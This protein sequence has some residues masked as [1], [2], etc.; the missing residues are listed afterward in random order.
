[1]DWKN[2]GGRAAEGQA[3]NAWI[4]AVPM[5]EMAERLGLDELPMRQPGFRFYE[6]AIYHLKQLGFEGQEKEHWALQVIQTLFFNIG[7]RAKGPEGPI[8]R[9]VRWYKKR[10]AKG[11]KPQPFDEYFKYAFRQK[12]FTARTRWLRQKQKSGLSI[13]YT[14][15]GEEEGGVGEE[16]F[17]ESREPSPYEV[18]R[19]KEENPKKEKA[20]AEVPQMLVEHRNGAAYETIWDLMQKQK[21]TGKKYTDEN[22][23]N[24]LNSMQIKAPGETAEWNGGAVSRA[25]Y[26]IHELVRKHLKERGIDWE[27]I[28]AARKGF[29][30]GVSLS[31]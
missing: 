26:T 23:A 2:R 11:L 19:A 13:N 5:R 3:T 10:V 20:L 14:M 9:Y 17:P 1:M 4:R 7:K 25:R 30:F 16:F 27:S 12:A 8:Y 31:R 24:I 29:R 6:H 15:G 28:S 18:L 21:E 22:M